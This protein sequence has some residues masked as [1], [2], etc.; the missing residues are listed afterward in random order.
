MNILRILN[1]SYDLFDRDVVNNQTELEAEIQSSSFLILGGGGSIG[2]E[3]SKQIFQRNPKRLYVVD[4]SENSLVELVRDIRSSM[5]YIDGDFKTFALDIGSLEFEALVIEN[6]PFDYIMNLTALKHV[7]SEKDKYT[8]MRM[9]QNNIAYTQKTIDLALK[10]GAKKY[11]SVSTDKA[12]NPVN[13][14]GGSKRVMENLL[15]YRGQDIKI[16]SARFANVAFS[17]GSL[18]QGFKNR[19]EKK[20]PIVAPN[21]VQRYFITPEE[22]GKLCMLSTVFGKQNEVYFPRI[23]EQF[24]LTKFN[25]IAVKFLAELGLKPLLCSSEDEARNMMKSCDISKCWPCYFTMSDTTGE[26]PYEE[27]HTHSEVP[28][29]KIYSGIGVL[30][31]KQSNESS[32]ALNF[33]KDLEELR[34]RSHWSKNDLIDLITA[35]VP[36]LDYNDLEK[37]LDQRM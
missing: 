1:R 6:G 3:L 2:R 14:M 32:R 33:L 30:T 35:Y 34:S 21:D 4:L 31:L 13:L 19:V 9:L 17:D 23:S 37:N 18:L 11:F 8:L 5:G 29:Y 7:R 15:T 36:E 10:V 16:S 25:D 24:G 12:A 27:F 20:Q 22:S 28:N 26:K